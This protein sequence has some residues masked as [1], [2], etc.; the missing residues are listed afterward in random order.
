MFISVLVLAA[1]TLL[2]FIVGNVMTWFPV[3][4][5]QAIPSEGRGVVD[6]GTELTYN[7]YPPSSGNHYDVGALW[8]VASEPVTEGVYLNNLARGGIVVLYAC[9][10]D[11]AAI[12]GQLADWAASVPREPVYNQRK[13]LISRYEREMPAPVV[14]LAWGYQLNLQSVDTGLLTQWYR[15]FVNQGPVQAP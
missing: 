2:V 9:E 13:V 10:T 4:G 1:V 14:A 5:E 15:R 12:E 6:V 11:C 8:G 7:T 3:P